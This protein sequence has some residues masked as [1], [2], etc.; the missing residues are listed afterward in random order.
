MKP[1]LIVANWKMN[2]LSKDAHEFALKIIS[3]VKILKNMEIVL[4]PPFTLLHELKITLMGCPVKIG[5]QDAFYEKAGAF[6]GEISAGML[7]DAGCEYVL[8][9][10][11]ERRQYFHETD[12]IVNKKIIAVIEAG[13]KPIM[14]I[15]EMLEHRKADRTFEIIDTQ[16]KA[17]LKSLSGENLKELSVAYEPVWAIGTGINATPEQ[18]EEVHAFIRGAVERDFSLS[19]IRILYGGSVTE[20]NSKSLLAKKNIDGL[21][22]GGASLDADRFA[23]IIRN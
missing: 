8:I 12:D 13:L 15:G 19:D 2:K 22:V 5:S 11:S 18:A 21:L 16:I 9:G 14:C 10:H 4:C 3:Q 23:K 7:K 20:A 17:G 6:T 1:T